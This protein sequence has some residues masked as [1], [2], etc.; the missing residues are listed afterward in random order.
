MRV[1]PGRATS[2]TGSAF[3]FSPHFRLVSVPYRSA[4]SSIVKRLTWSLSIPSHD[5]HTHTL[6]L[7]LGLTQ[8]Q[9]PL[10]SPL[11][12][13]SVPFGNADHIARHLPLN[14]PSVDF[15]SLL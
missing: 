6:S 13:S 4:S 7:S 9:P 15:P 12:D 5:T 2:A 8:S 11:C 10:S 14:S 3:A 1:S